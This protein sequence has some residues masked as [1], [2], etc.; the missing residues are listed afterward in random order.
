MMN[1]QEWIENFVDPLDERCRRERAV[2]HFCDGLPTAVLEV[3]GDGGAQKLVEAA[4]ERL[5]TDVC[6]LCYDDGCN[7]SGPFG[8]E[9]N[10]HTWVERANDKLAAALAPFAQE[11]GAEGEA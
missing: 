5:S 4:Q 6:D 7:T 1:E 10:C 8:C 3:A 2:W 11:P 9:C